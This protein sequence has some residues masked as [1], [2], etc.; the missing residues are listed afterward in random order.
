M[1]DLDRQFFLEDRGYAT[2]RIKHYEW[3][4]DKNKIITKLIRMIQP[5]SNEREPIN[6]A[7]FAK[8]VLYDK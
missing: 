2:Y 4:L 1:E 8:K 5:S 6:V 3:F 7:V